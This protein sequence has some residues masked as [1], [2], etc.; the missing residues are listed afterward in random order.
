MKPPYDHGLLG[1][2]PWPL[3]VDRL[4]MRQWAKLCMRMRCSDAEY[5]AGYAAESSQIRSQILTALVG[6]DVVLY[7]EVLAPCDR[8]TPVECRSYQT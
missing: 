1:S 5:E 6:H 8:L 4:M 2:V 7:L 3:S